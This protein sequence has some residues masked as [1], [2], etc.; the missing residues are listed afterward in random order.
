M[1]GMGLTMNEPQIWTIIGVLA[2]TMIGLITLITQLFMRQ[3]T[4][5][6]EVLRS[7][8]GTKIDLTAER[9]DTRITSLSTEMVLRFEQVD[10]RFEQVDR[11]LGNLELRVGTLE[12]Q[13]ERL[14]RK[15]DDIDRDVQGIVKRVFPE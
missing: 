12:G 10:Q 3:M 5:Q 14:D 2:A 11:R 13:V 1:K 6:F 9:L 15:V 4:T 8:L 7:E